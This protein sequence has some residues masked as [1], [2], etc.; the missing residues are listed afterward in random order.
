M[1]GY[2]FMRCFFLFDIIEQYWDK[3]YCYYLKFY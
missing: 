1:Q 3:G 2:D